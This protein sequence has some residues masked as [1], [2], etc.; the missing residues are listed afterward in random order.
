MNR[1]EILQLSGATLLS[2]LFMQ[3]AF[4][5]GG[6]AALSAPIVGPVVLRMRASSK[7]ENTH[8]GIYVQEV[9]IVDGKIVPVAL[10]ACFE[11]GRKQDPFI[12][13]ELISTQLPLIAPRDLPYKIAV[14][15]FEN[16]DVALQSHSDAN[17]M[18]NRFDATFDALNRTAIMKAS[19]WDHAELPTANMLDISLVFEYPD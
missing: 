19:Y 6:T 16:R 1:R 3:S 12:Y 11:F 2:P 18:A 8:W 13:P 9:V 10:I 7:S 4:A 14:Y 17:M 15:F 5:L